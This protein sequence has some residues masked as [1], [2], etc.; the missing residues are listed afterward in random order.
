MGLVGYMRV[1]PHAI[2]KIKIRWQGSGFNYI[3]GFHELLQGLKL[4]LKSHFEGL[5]WGITSH[6]MLEVRIMNNL[7][8]LQC[9][10]MNT[11]THNEKPSFVYLTKLPKHW[12]WHVPKLLD[13]LKCEVEV[14]TTEEQRVGAHSLARNTLGVEGRAGASGWD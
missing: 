2:F 11:I 4:T 7:N 6:Y 9:I 10:P 1:T 8:Y 13:R 12:R 3:L 14:K 5:P